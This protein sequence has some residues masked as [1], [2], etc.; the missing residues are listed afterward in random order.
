[1]PLDRR[2]DTL[3]LACAGLWHLLKSRHG[4]SDADLVA[5]IEAAD[6]ADGV[7]DGKASGERKNPCPNCKRTPLTKNHE[8]CLWCGFELDRSPI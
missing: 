6:A 7:V 5:A 4:Y 8:V 3:E 1:M 2:L